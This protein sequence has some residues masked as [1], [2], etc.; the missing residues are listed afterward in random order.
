MRAI[1]YPLLLVALLLPVLAC[2]PDAP[3][4]PRLAFA[5]LDGQVL[6]AEPFVVLP[7]RAWREHP[8]RRV[9]FFGEAATMLCVVRET[10]AEPI[11][12]GFVPEDPELRLELGVT[13]D[14]DDVAS[15]AHQ[16]EDSDFPGELQVTIPPELLTPGV[17][18][19]TLSRSATNDGSDG[20]DEPPT[21]LFIGHRY[22]GRPDPLEIEHRQSWAYLAN[23]VEFGVTGTSAVESFGGMALKGPGRAIVELPSGRG[24]ELRFHLQNASYSRGYFSITAGDARQSWELTTQDDLDVRFEVPDGISEIELRAEGEANGFYLWGAPLFRPRGAAPRPP[25]VL[26]TLDT[27]RRDALGAY[28]GEGEASFTPHLDAFAA[29]AEVFDN[30]RTTA[31]WTL[32][33]HASMMTGLYPT[34]HGA[35]VASDHLESTFTTL[36]E[37]LRG[38]GYM[39]A[40]LAG[41]TLCAF[42]FGIGQGFSVYHDPHGFETV[43]DVLTD[44]T[45]DILQRHADAP[46]FL[47]VNYFDPHFPFRAPP[48]IARRHGVPE[49]PEGT[50]GGLLGAGAAEGDAWMR[51]ILGE[52]TLEKV[53]VDVL[54]SAYRAEIEGMDAQLGRLFAALRE[55]GL[56]DDA[57]IA[58]TA[59]H[60][61]LLGEGGFYSHSSRLDSE[62]VEVPL[63]I[64]WPGGAN[65]GRRADLVSTVDLFPTLARFGGASVPATDGRD[66]RDLDALD[67]R[68]KVLMEEHDAGFHRLF[69][70]MRIAD[71]LY[72]LDARRNGDSQDG[73]PAAL[74]RHWRWQDGE[75]CFER[76]ATGPWRP[77]PCSP[78]GTAETDAVLDAL[79]ADAA[80]PRVERIGLSHEERERLRALGYLQ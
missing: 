77:R 72:S 10:P 15:R 75:R 51:L 19:L 27:T 62:L 30:A 43:G 55:H 20:E 35:G 7:N 79:R 68:S 40:G 38:Q 16:V 52:I 37:H 4:A 54:R 5:E 56:W 48:E 26:I 24:G 74:V 53:E 3:P 17:H 8:E 18:H 25:I 67:A 22:G 65:A 42:R 61:E 39:T 1:V 11:V 13:W 28:R 70:S 14:G 71:A 66:L 58:I 21:F 32:P 80:R 64:K 2:A 41:G 46:L 31:P 76:P 59:D 44:E 36:A 47:F 69:D 60:G 49:A 78:E 63:M 57:L 9:W 73:D 33:A 34:R 50:L 12:F 29:E 6:A 23:L 45:L